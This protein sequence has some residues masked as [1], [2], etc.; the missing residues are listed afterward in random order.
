VKRLI[1][2]A[3]KLR[4][5]TQHPGTSMKVIA[6]I[7]E[8]DDDHEYFPAGESPGAVGPFGQYSPSI[9]PG[10]TRFLAIPP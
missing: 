3:I 6:A 7:D 8:V 5:P 2:D 10:S 4:Q 1:R 9:A